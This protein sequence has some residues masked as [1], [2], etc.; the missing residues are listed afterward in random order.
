MARKPSSERIPRD[1][2][3]PLAHRE[4]LVERATRFVDSNKVLLSLLFAYLFIRMLLI[5]TQ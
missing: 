2:L 5:A 1:G 4:T 3:I